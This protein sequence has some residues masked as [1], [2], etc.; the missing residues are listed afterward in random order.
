LIFKITNLGIKKQL[1][2]GTGMTKIV[3]KTGIKLNNFY[4]TSRHQTNDFTIF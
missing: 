1:Q 4:R 3:K 2:E